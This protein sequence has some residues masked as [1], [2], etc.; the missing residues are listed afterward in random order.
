MEFIAIIPARSG[1]KGI[2]NKNT[3]II[4]KKKLIEYTFQVAKKSKHIKKIFVT[5]ND[6][7]VI[8]VAKKYKYIKILLRKKKLSLSKSL[9]SEA[10]HDALK[11]SRTEFPNISNFILLQP[12]SPQRTLIDIEN[13]IKIFKKNKHENLISISEPINHPSEMISFSKNKYSFLIKKKKQMNRQEYKQFYFIN[14]SIFI[15]SINKFLKNKNFLDDKNIF[16][17]MDKKNSIDI[18]NE[19]DKE[20]VKNFL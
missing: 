11:R 3:T 20:L 13:A 10:I 1:S 17:K 16:F 18:N 8:N 6:K 15:G 4:N 5:T 14:G 12:T 19:F 9:I 2:V 7:N